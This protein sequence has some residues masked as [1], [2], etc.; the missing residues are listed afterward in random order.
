[1]GVHDGHR[2]RVRERFVKHGLDNFDDITALEFLLFYAIPRRDTNEI[3]HALLEHFGSIDNVFSADIDALTSVPGIGENAAA[4]IKLV[5][6]LMKKSEL[7]S[8]NNVTT[9]K[10]KDQL[11]EYLV[12]RFIDEIDEVL[13]ILCLDSNFELIQIVEIGRGDV[14]SVNVSIRKIT[15]IALKYHASNIVLSHNHPRGR[16]VPSGDDIR[17]TRQIRDALRVMD[18]ELHDHIVVAG[19]KYSS[20]RES[21]FLSTIYI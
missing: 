5:P 12:P 21:G 3:A 6:Q 2:E 17:Y 13:Y 9:L 14:I 19:R 1:M 7:A 10:T 11:G 16:A 18:V 8:L 20:F 4:L 15:E